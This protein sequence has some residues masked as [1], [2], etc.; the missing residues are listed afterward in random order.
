MDPLLVNDS[1]LR[2]RPRHGFVVPLSDEKVQ[3][4]ADHSYS[5][6]G[7]QRARKGTMDYMG[8]SFDE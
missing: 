4:G 2:P 1:T 6:K 5:R 7:K 8:S 3:F